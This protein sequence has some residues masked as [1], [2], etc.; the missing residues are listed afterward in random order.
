M[1][2][3]NPTPMMLQGL[4]DSAPFLL[5]IVPFGMLFGVLATEAGLKIGETMAMTVLVI[6][7]AAQFAALQQMVADTPVVM[8]ILTALAVNLRMAMY[9]ASLTPHLG[10]APLWQRALL[11]YLMVDQAFVLS[12]AK[13]ERAPELS[14]SARVRYYVGT[15]VL[16][17]PAW[18]TATLFGALG[19]RAIPPGFALDFAAPITFLAMIGPMLRTLPHLVAAIVSIVLALAFHGFPYGTGLL[20]AAAAAMAAGVVTEQ[21]M[22]RF[23]P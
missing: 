5:V 22:G 20:V 14:L 13:Y 4:R 9:S 12:A 23:R 8:I 16:T 18:Y 21:A 17:A 7:G 6:A 2:R 10:K 11:A 15:M 1:S 19:A 3:K